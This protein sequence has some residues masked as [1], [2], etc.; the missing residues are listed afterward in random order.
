MQEFRRS[1]IYDLPQEETRRKAV[2]FRST[3]SEYGGFDLMSRFR[4]TSDN[5]LFLLKDIYR[6]G[7]QAD[8]SEKLLAVLIKGHRDG[9]NS[10]I[11]FIFFNRI[12]IRSDFV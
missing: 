8:G 2:D 11:K 1:D 9:G 4:Q 3:G 5:F 7:R 12:L 6:C 10:R